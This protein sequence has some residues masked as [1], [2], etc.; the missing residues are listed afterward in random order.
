MVA[1]NVG[2]PPRKGEKTMKLRMIITFS[3]LLILLI[4]AA[5][6]GTDTPTQ[7]ILEPTQ[8]PTAEPSPTPEPTE[9]PI[10]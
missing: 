9:I 10:E 2:M 5:C 3:A 1:S 6:Q 8:D 4:S 7:E